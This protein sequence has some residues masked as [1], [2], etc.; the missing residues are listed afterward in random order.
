MEDTNRASLLI[1]EDNPLVADMYG[2]AFEKAHF[3]IVFA[4]NGEDG[5]ALAREIK[6]SCV[7]L[8]LLMPGVNGLEVLQRLRNDART[9]NTH[10]IVVTSIAD[11]SEL[12][13][14]RQL[15]ATECL[16]KS[17]VSLSEIVGK[18]T[19]FC[20]SGISEPAEISPCSNAD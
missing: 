5:I 11:T 8:D 19:S 13:K 4:S 18:V 7:I 6:P 3:K 9:K 1:I 12:E 17:D 14:A 2:Q 20:R 15:G 16:V 10:I